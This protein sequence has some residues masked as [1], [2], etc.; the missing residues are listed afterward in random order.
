MESSSHFDKGL[1]LYELGRHDAAEAEFRKALAQEPDHPGAHAFLGAVL[2]AQKKPELALPEA[3]L[4]IRCAPGQSFP[5]FILSM[6]EAGTGRFNE[7]EKSIREALRL[8]PDSVTNLGGAS[9]I[10]AARERWDES[11]KYAEAGLS[12]DPESVRCINQRAEALVRLG[13]A[14]EAEESLDL[15]LQINPEDE[16]THSNKGWT[17]VRRGRVDEAIDHFK[18]ALRLDPNSTWAY[19]GIVEALKA[20]NPIYHGLLMVSLW[21]TELNT[22]VRLALFWICWVIPPLR[23]LLFLIAAIGVFT[24]LV[25]TTLLRLDPL[26]RRV[27][28]DAAKKENNT[29]LAL[30]LSVVLLFTVARLVPKPPPSA[31]QKQMETAQALYQDGKKQE[32]KK[33]WATAYGEALTVKPTPGRESEAINKFT[34]ISGA[35]HAL[36]DAQ[37]LRIYSLIQRGDIE[38]RQQKVKLAVGCYEEATNAASNAGDRKLQGIALLC[39]AKAYASNPSDL[40]YADMATPCLDFLTE[41]AGVLRQVPGWQGSKDDDDVTASIAL[42]KAKQEEALPTVLETLTRLT[43]LPDN[44]QF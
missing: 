13:R 39:Q 19:E 40:W 10:A 5:Y 25:F 6:A 15:A 26:G 4:A 32:A 30:A 36:G 16:R 31:W 29:S 11:L 1:A 3:K 22:N 28:S 18:E 42:L 7:A 23:V 2:L 43:Q 35:T 21:F 8:E 33:L 44:P 12:A 24:R 37:L 34:D 20:R 38:V 27:L 17:L 9:L 14:A 41:A